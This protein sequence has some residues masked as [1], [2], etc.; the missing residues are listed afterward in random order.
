MKKLVQLSAYL[1]LVGIILS[2]CSPIT[3]TK[4][5]YKKGFYTDFGFKNQARNN[6]TVSSEVKETEYA[7]Q[8]SVE[9][10]AIE[11]S[12]SVTV[13]TP[14][15]TATS[16]MDNPTEDKQVLVATEETSEKPAGIPTLKSKM[17]T[18]KQ[19]MK[20]A[21][22]IKKTLAKSPASGEA[23]SLLWIIVVIILILWLISLLFGGFGLG[24]LI[25]LLLVVALIL[26]ILWLLRII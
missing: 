6:K 2:S 4:R 22:K 16:V 12:A 10:P 15:E 20:N 11:E 1:L 3:I 5:H 13:S 9:E 18:A 19:V 24:G 8:T 17:E 26:L 14:P 21:N 25:H 7:A 23:H